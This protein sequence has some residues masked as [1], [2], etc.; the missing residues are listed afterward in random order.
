MISS[1]EGKTRTLET[2]TTIFKRNM[3]VNYPLKMKASRST[4]AEV[5]TMFGGM[6]FSLRQCADETT[7]RMGLQECVNHDLI[8]PFTVLHEKD[9]AFVAHFLYTVLL[10]SSG[11]QKITEFPWNQDLI[12]SEKSLTNPDVIELLKTDVLAKRSV[13][14]KVSI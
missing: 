6:A 12:K 13:K 9:D 7:S 3:D 2:R 5:N 14:K 1:G 8:M 4:L 10:T 11:T